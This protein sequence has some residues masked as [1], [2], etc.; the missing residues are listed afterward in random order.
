MS[1]YQIR[2]ISLPCRSHPTT[3]KIEEELNN[4]KTWE[5]TSSTSD[6]ICK[7][8]CRLA[9][10]YK[11]MDDLLNLPQT[12]QAPFQQHQN[13]KWG[14][15]FL[16]GSVTILDICSITR[17]IVSLLKDN[18]RDLQSTLRRRKGDSSILETSISKYISFR[19]KMKKD[20]KSSI[21]ALKQIDQEIADSSLAAF[22]EHVSSV[23]RVLREVNS[24]C[25]AIF[26]NVLLFLSSQ[27]SKPNKL[28]K[29]SLV[30]MLMNKGKVGCENDSEKVENELESVDSALFNLCRR[31]GDE[32]E[33]EK[34]QFVQNKLENLEASIEGL[35]NGLEGIFSQ[36]PYLYCL[37]SINADVTSSKVEQS[38]SLACI[39]TA[40]CDEAA[41]T[42]FDTKYV[43]R[44]TIAS[45]EITQTTEASLA[46]KQKETIIDVHHHGA[47]AQRSGT[48][49]QD[50]DI[51]V[52][53]APV[54]ST[55]AATASKPIFSATAISEIA[56]D[57]AVIWDCSID[58][59]TSRRPILNAAAAWTISSD[60][61]VAG[62]T[63]ANIAAHKFNIDVAAPEEA[64]RDDD[65][66]IRN[67]D[68]DAATFPK[69][70]TN[71]SKKKKQKK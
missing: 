43:G 4:I 18:V 29:W 21:S 45:T 7:G 20:A 53:A 28:S 66:L 38:P 32:S 67:F 42:P 51:H 68:D 10:L 24:T 17:E 44:A 64:I 19:K 56:D 50:L 27:F 57:F 30:S 62:K 3:L 37:N 61:T 71:A 69:C 47:A 65:V 35:E 34:I 49:V 23:I 41:P 1:T 31:N 9:E 52:A 33:N 13:E 39:F 15:E 46:F 59:T 16:D 8:L 22:D 36:H 60:A 6:A 63:D 70:L 54:N 11:C 58:D 12:I 40:D 2:S 26:Q 5:T 48:S 14:C 25:I 55:N